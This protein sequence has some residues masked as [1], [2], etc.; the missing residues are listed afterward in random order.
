MS[1]PP[2]EPWATE[3]A[4]TDPAKETGSGE[5]VALAFPNADMWL[6]EW[7]L[8]IWQPVQAPDAVPSAPLSSSG[9]NV[10]WCPKW[11]AHPEAVNRIELL[12]RSW[13]ELRH[14]AMMGMSIWF[15]DHFDYHWPKLV[16]S[17]GVFTYCT[18]HVHRDLASVR[19]IPIDVHLGQ[20]PITE[21]SNQPTQ[22]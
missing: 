13:E 21:G 9:A 14:D 5:Q 8:Q 11:W 15:R 10:H 2:Q 7:L 17:G 22:R 1:Q 3:G 19:A 12:W 18:E 20:R 6:R 16:G 4:R